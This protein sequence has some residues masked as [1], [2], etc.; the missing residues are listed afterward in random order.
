MTGET[1]AF[2]SALPFVVGWK[3]DGD[4][5]Y[6]N[7]NT[8]RTLEL[9]ALD[10][11][12]NRIAIENLTVHVLAQEYVSVLTKE[13][14][15]S[16]PYQS[17]LKERLVRSETVAISASG[18]R[19]SLPTSEPGAFVVEWRDD[20]NRR[21]AMAKFYVAGSGAVGTSLLRLTPP[22]QAIANQNTVIFDFARF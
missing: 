4:L 18:T 17:V 1:D 13:E 22:E 14:S 21:V 15:G 7:A 16:Y 11:Q 20:H 2:V 6:L 19:Y 9:I 12:L 10:P 5:R 8:P 3:E